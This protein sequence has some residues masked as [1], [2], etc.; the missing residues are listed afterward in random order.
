MGSFFSS[1]LFNL[2]GLCSLN[3]LKSNYNANEI[4]LYS[5]D[6]LAIIEQKTNQS[7][8]KKIKLFKK[9]IGFKITI[10]VGIT[11]FNFLD[12]TNNIYK[13]CLIKIK[14]KIYN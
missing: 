5:D 13:P 6:G 11:V 14:I 9:D 8:E 3:R 2:V 7:L 10:D 12:M 1:K 4:G